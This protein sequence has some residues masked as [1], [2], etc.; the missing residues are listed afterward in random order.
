MGGAEKDLADSTIRYLF[1]ISCH[2][3]LPSAPKSRRAS[4]GRKMLPRLLIVSFLEV[5]KAN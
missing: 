2:Q 1:S 4:R 3:L 5:S